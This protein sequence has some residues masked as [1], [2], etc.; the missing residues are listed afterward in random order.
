MHRVSITVTT[1]LVPGTGFTSSAGLLHLVYFSS[2][3]TQKS[4]AE[5]A[6]GRL[7]SLMYLWAYE[8]VLLLETFYLTNCTSYAG[9]TLGRAWIVGS[10]FSYSAFVIALAI[11]FSQPDAARTVFGS[12]LLLTGLVTSIIA[13]SDSGMLSEQPRCSLRVIGR[14]NEG[15]A[16]LL[17]VW[18]WWACEV[19]ASL[20]LR[21]RIVYGLIFTWAAAWGCVSETQLGRYTALET[22]LGA[23]IGAACAVL[24]HIAGEQEWVRRGTKYFSAG[25]LSSRLTQRT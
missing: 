11:C 10:L 13:A 23:L 7:G 19:V 17:F 14:P 20:D 9:G 25:Y 22:G 24:A 21:R 5:P 15:A 8:I 6:G 12:G 3:A 2:C 16:L 4:I 1:G 18:T